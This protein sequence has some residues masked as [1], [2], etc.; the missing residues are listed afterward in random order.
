MSGQAVSAAGA[1]WREIMDDKSF[2]NIARRLG[3]LRSRRAALKTAGG[4]AAVVFTALGLETSALAQVSIEN[5]CKVPGLSCNK[6][7]QCCGAKKKSKEIVCDL[8]NA[9]TGRR[10]CGRN[11]ASCRDDNDCCLNYFCNI[12]NECSLI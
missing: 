4:A 5:H 9:G 2:D 1:Q 6:K 7:K 8:S 3:G 12:A 11:R 10:C